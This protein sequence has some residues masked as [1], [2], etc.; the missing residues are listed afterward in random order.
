MPEPAAVK[1]A[2]D[3]TPMLGFRTGIGTA[4]AEIVAALGQRSDISVL[5]YALSLRARRERSRVP[6]ETRFPPIPARVLLAAWGRFNGPKLDRFLGDA[7]VVHAT[8]YLSAPSRLPTLVSVWDCSFVRFA[9]LVSDEVRAFEPVLRRALARGAHVHTASHAMAAEIDDVFGPGLRGTG[10][11][12]VVPLAVP[13][14][15]TA[16]TNRSEAV[17]NRSGSDADEI[18]ASDVRIPALATAPYVLA[19]GR[20][21]P[22]KDLPLLVRAFG[23]V[24]TAERELHLALIGP[25]GSGSGDLTAAI[26]ALPASVRNRVHMLGSV[27]DRK[28][29][30]LLRDATLLC[31]P[32][33]YEGFGFPVLEAMNAGVAVVAS[34]T[35]SIPEV[36]G[37]AAALV[38]VGDVDRL[39]TVIREIVTDDARRA[40]LATAG[41]SRAA[42]FSWAATAHGLASVYAELAR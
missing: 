7:E 3:V 32:S 22:R 37:D 27:D 4:V 12:H 15:A 34:A 38:P 13:S 30:Q 33:R 11:V 36:A 35:G 9:E 23:M 41:R 18:D 42:E 2:T 24:A 10:R 8:N 16:G 20:H 25:A 19:I 31:Y 26:D 21:E 5:P 6:P 39:A 14:D 29:G 28:K 40:R 1:V 17:P